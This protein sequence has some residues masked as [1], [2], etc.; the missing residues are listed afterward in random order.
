MTFSYLLRCVHAPGYFPAPV[1]TF[2]AC[3][4]PQFVCGLLLSVQNIFRK[5]VI[6]LVGILAQGM[7]RLL[8][9]ISGIEM[10]VLVC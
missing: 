7:P 8:N 2:S 3:T 1:Y 4:R 9:E 5:H 6:S 10:F